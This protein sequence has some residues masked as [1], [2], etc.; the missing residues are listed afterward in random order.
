M[1]IIALGIHP[2][3]V[4]AKRVLHRLLEGTVRYL[5]FSFGKDKKMEQF[6]SNCEM[7]SVNF[8]CYTCMYTVG[9]EPATC[10]DGA[11]QEPIEYKRL[12]IYRG[13]A[14]C[15]FLMLRCCHDLSFAIETALGSVACLARVGRP[16]RACPDAFLSLHRVCTRFT[17]SVI[18][19]E[20]NTGMR[21]N[22]FQHSF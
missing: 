18:S 11:S 15:I 13:N 20:V 14:C 2:Q 7:P 17:H 19:A 10:V 21:I 4:E 9:F 5:L 22:S 16:S 12:V 6:P 1:N 8:F 3:S